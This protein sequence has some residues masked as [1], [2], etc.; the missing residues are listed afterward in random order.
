VIPNHP[1]DIPQGTLKAILTQLG[2]DRNEFD[3][4]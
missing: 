3:A 2:I 1:G 4:A